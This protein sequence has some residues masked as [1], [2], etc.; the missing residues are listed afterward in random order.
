MQV[1]AV[2]DVAACGCNPMG[3]VRDDCEQMTGRCMCR[4]GV[5]GQKCAVCSN[6]NQLITQGSCEGRL[7]QR[8][9]IVDYTPSV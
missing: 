5:T 7:L 4:P 9:T 2:A 8:F 6:G 3:S 1:A